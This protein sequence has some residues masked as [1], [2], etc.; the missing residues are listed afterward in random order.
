M[1][2]LSEQDE[3]NQSQTLE[4][5]RRRVRRKGESARDEFSDADEQ[6]YD[7]SEDPSDTSSP[8]PASDTS[9]GKE[10]EVVEVPIRD[11]R[12][13]G[14]AAAPTATMNKES[15]RTDREAAFSGKASKSNDS[16]ETLLADAKRLRAAKGG[17]DKKGSSIGDTLSNVVST[18]VTTDFFVVCALL[19]WFLVGVFCSYVLKDDT[20]QIAFNDI[21]QPIVQPALGIL[22]I[23]SA[24]GALMKKGDDN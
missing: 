11:V 18:I 12:D 5:K 16:L 8:S 6:E 22:M 10:F 21:F 19:L 13:L 2:S 3:D 17:S 15:S 14:R 24:A 4:R 20:V 9:I 7:D 23:G 1:S